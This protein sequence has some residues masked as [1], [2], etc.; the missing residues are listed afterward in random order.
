MLKIEIQSEDCRVKQG[1][2]AKTGKPYHL[3]EQFGFAFT[4]NR[5][6][7][8][9]PY[10]Q[11]CCFMLEDDQMPYKPGVYVLGTESLWINR[12]GQLEI[13]PILRPYIE[14]IHGKYL[15]KKAA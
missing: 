9:H 7:Q 14:A 1:V 6:G 8:P 12:F 15:D 3:R 4:F 10:P 11:R 13:K 5:E 2:S